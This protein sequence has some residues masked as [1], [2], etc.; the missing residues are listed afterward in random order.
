MALNKLFSTLPLPNA[1]ADPNAA[2]RVYVEVCANYSAADAELAVRQ[3]ISGTVAGHNPAWAPTA[4]QFATQ[5]RKNLDYTATQ[6]ASR[7]AMIEQFRQQDDDAEFRKNITPESIAKVRSMVEGFT[8][9]IDERT[10]EQ[11]AETQATLAK[12][13]AYYAGDYIEVGDIRVSRSLAGQ[14]GY[15]GGNDE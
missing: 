7:N 8:A 1:N 14:L 9:K 10:P 15:T 5:M 4:A 12:Q 2:L 3:F 11:I 13:D 6:R